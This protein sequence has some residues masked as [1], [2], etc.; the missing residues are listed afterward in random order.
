MGLGTRCA[1][2]VGIPVGLPVRARCEYPR[3]KLGLASRAL[4]PSVDHLVPLPAPEAT[5]SWIVRPAGGTVRGRFYTYGSRLDRPTALLARNGWAFVAVDVQGQVLASA[6]GLPPPWIVD[7]PGAEAW[8]LLQ[9]A[10][11]AELGSEYRLDCEPCVN[12]VK[13]GKAWA[14]AAAR[15][16]ARVFG[17][18][19]SAI[20]D[21]PP[22]AF[23]RMPSH[24]G[25]DEVGK[26]RLS[27]GTLL[28][29]I[30]RRSNALADEHAKAAVEVHRV[31]LDVRRE[32]KN[33]AERVRSIA[34]WLGRV[35][36]LASSRPGLQRRDTEA[37]RRARACRRAAGDAR[38]GA[39]VRCATAETGRLLPVLEPMRARI[40]ARAAA[41]QPGIT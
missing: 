6:H 23:A 24:C 2:G 16:L 39:T 5:F 26:A 10:M 14:T 31:P 32:V 35:T 8:A 20:D 4:V 29:D 7:I 1:V 38:A 9:A 25:L 3:P 27:D 30:D 28:A 21:T 40:A 18:V 13:R 34:M 37:T 33:A 17:L 12:A 22:E 36:H 41:R 11:V 19:F 15:P